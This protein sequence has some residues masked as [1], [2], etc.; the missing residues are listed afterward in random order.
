MYGVQW[1]GHT[2][3][4]SI[5]RDGY[6][7]F[8][9]DCLLGMWAEAGF[10]MDPLRHRRWRGNPYLFHREQFTRLFDH[11]QPACV[12]SLASGTGV[13]TAA[14]HIVCDNPARK[15]IDDTCRHEA[16]FVEQVQV[17]VDVLTAAC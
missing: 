5:P 11:Y 13:R 2:P 17:A 10:G 4:R 1:L 12:F 7:V 16:S 14:I 9:A 15:D 3:G 6:R 8:E